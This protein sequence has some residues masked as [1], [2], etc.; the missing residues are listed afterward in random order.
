MNTQSTAFTV[1]VAL[2]SLSLMVQHVGHRRPGKA[3]MVALI[4]E[5]EALLESKGDS[6]AWLSRVRDINRAL[7]VR[8]MS[9]AAY[10]A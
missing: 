5:G 9:Q 6:R 7:S 10:D 1:E 2:Q 8:Q 4:R 3:S